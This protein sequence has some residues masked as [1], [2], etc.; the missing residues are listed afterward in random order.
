[1]RWMGAKFGITCLAF[2]A[3]FIVLFGVFVEYD[4]SADASDEANQKD[5]KSLNEVS[6]YYPSKFL[7]LLSFFIIFALVGVFVE[8]DASADASDQV[9][10]KS[11]NE[12]SF[13]YPSK[14]EVFFPW[15]LSVMV[16]WLLLPIHHPSPHHTKDAVVVVWGELNLHLPTKTTRKPHR[17]RMPHSIT[18]LTQDLTTGFKRSKLT[19]GLKRSCSRLGVVNLLCLSP[20]CSYVRNMFQT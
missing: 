8:Y 19:A 18:R 1:M 15:D 6:F 4:A 16:V 10:E 13:Y 12:V 5:Q 7:L 9:D 11:L 14:S 17:V 3:A 20:M 2:Q